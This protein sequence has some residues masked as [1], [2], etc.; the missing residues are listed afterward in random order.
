MRHQVS[1]RKLGRTTSHREAMFRN[2]AASLIEYGRIRTTLHKAKELRGI[3]EH[4]ITLGKKN[5][6]HTRRQAFDLLRNR[7]T[8]KKLFESIA[9]AFAKRMGGYTR[10]FR[11]DARPGDAAQSA[12]IEYLSEDLLTAKVEGKVDDVK[13]EE[14]AKAKKAKADKPKKEV[15]AASQGN[16]DAKVA[17]SK[18]KKAVAKRVVKKAG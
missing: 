1:G 3:A 14:K 17:V 15:K 12:L 10:I 18:P 16:D 2:M 11:L 9:P 4:L 7:D 6:L 8:V 5:T 13:K